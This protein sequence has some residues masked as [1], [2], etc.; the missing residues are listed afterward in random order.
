M[1]PR[2]APRRSI[3][4]ALSA[5]LLATAAA[6]DMAQ[7]TAVSA[8][9]SA[10]GI[11]G[12]VTVTVPPN[13]AALD[14]DLLV[15]V[16]QL[17]L[18]EG[19]SVFEDLVGGAALWQSLHWE[20]VRLGGDTLEPHVYSKPTSLPPIEPGKEALVMVRDKTVF[21]RFRPS[22]E[23]SVGTS[24]HKFAINGK[25][26][27]LESGTEAKVDAGVVGYRVNPIA[28]VDFDQMATQSTTGLLALLRSTGMTG[29]DAERESRIAALKARGEFLGDL[30]AMLSK[31][32]AG[33]GTGTALGIALGA[34]ILPQIDPARFTELS[35]ATL[36]NKG[37][38]SFAE[39]FKQNLEP[40]KSI[41]P[42]LYKV[43]EEHVIPPEGKADLVT[44]ILAKAAGALPPSELVNFVLTVSS[45]VPESDAAVFALAAGPSL[46]RGMASWAV[47]DIQKVLGLLAKWKTATAVPS[48][49]PP[50]TWPVLVQKVGEEALAN[51]VKA[52]TQEVMPIEVVRLMGDHAEGRRKFAF[53]V[54]T[55]G[56]LGSMTTVA[57][58]LT[59]LGYPPKEPLGAEAL[60]KDAKLLEKLAGRLQGIQLVP[61]AADYEAKAARLEQ[62][63][64]DCTETLL[65]ARRAIH[66]EL[67]LPEPLWA[68]CRSLS[69]RRLLEEGKVEEAV[70]LVREAFADAPEDAKVERR[71]KEIHKKHAE[72]QIR[73]GDFAAATET[74]AAVDPA[75]RD[76]EFIALLADIK[77]E[78][79]RLAKARGDRVGAV[80][81]YSEA[82][83]LDY[84][85]TIP[86]D[87]LA[88]PTSGTRQFVLGALWVCLAA[89]VA[90]GL[91][92]FRRRRIALTEFMNLAEGNPRE[93]HGPAGRRVLVASH[94]LLSLRPFSHRIVPWSEVTSVLKMPA[95][96]GH[97]GGLLIW[98][99]GDDAFFIP[100]TAVGHYVD[101]VAAVSEF[102]KD[103]NVDVTD[104]GAL[105][106]EK[107]VDSFDMA[108]EVASRDLRRRLGGLAALGIAGLAFALFALLD[109]GAGLERFHQLLVGSGLAVGVGLI[110]AWV[111][112]RM[113]PYSRA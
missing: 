3:I 25:V 79:G 18:A 55:S 39:R 80:A 84:R 50:E 1:T 42:M 87:L 46:L 75:R 57:G 72:K 6:A 32:L 98:Q 54:V 59:N 67:A 86:D 68:R 96:E 23:V 94:A 83:R 31:E 112:D 104:A 14:L 81:L 111:V 108:R 21:I 65:E 5:S 24:T 38:A 36:D 7:V 66:P 33:G 71:M 12:S 43:A 41:E 22:A 35:V 45:K 11:S 61:L 60:Q 85:H 58:E 4:I 29:S 76:P 109:V 13:R 56:G 9:V 64:T 105:D 74:I 27:G 78:Q 30:T 93:F 90:A 70:K 62:A 2:S 95:G 101:L 51:A 37:R 28:V 16:S 44:R 26:P 69:A 82:H 34:W 15:R 77:S 8:T 40:L 20:K 97:S 113:F 92:R 89:G 63:N 100:Q 52:M 19:R 103:E 73:A 10:S 47:E 17:P 107:T 91:T 102:L 99:G 49:L 53:G 106:P 88:D 48:L 110:L